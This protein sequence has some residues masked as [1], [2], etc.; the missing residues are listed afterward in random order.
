[1]NIVYGNETSQVM[2]KAIKTCVVLKT[3]FGKKFY[4]SAILLELIKLI[5]PVLI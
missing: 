3:A 1:M 4:P 2:I 5:F